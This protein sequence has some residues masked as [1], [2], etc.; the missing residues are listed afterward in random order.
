MPVVTMGVP[1]VVAGCAFV[2]PVGNGPCVKAQWV[3]GAMRVLA[4]GTPV[5]LRDSQAICA[6]TGTPLMIVQ[7]QARVRGM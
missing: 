2:A 3:T 1:Y 4:L 6:P 7:T 5:L